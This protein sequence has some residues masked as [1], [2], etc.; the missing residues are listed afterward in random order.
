MEFITWP[1]ALSIVG[2]LVVVLTFLKT[3][4]KR[5]DKPWENEMIE[6]KRESLNNDE[7]IKTSIALNELS[8]EEIKNRLFELKK[9]I[10]NDRKSS[11][12]DIHKL[13]DKIEKLTQ[14][15]IDILQKI[16]FY[17]NNIK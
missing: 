14:L 17:E 10:D 8:I 5:N 6:H 7:K 4:I 16:N 13:E 3:Y 12:K 11:V 9:E 2:T 1:I 15:M